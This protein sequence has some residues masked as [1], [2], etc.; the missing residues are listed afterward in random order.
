MNGTT[1]Q[2]GATAAIALVVGGGGSIAAL[3]TLGEAAGLTTEETVLKMIETQSKA[4]GHT[5]EPVVRQMISDLCPYTTD[6]N[7]IVVSLAS[8]EEAVKANTVAM[9]EL[10]TTVAV[11]STRVQLGHQGGSE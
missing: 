6:R 1:K 5:T 3:K 8:V 7:V 2:W 10:R 9:S 11:L 4:E